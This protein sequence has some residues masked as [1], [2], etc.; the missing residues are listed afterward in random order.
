MEVEELRLAFSEADRW[1]TEAEAFKRDR[2]AF[3]LDGQ[4]GSD[5]AAAQ[6]GLFLHVLPLGRL[7]AQASLAA[8]IT[9]WKPR[10]ED[11]GDEK[12]TIARTNVDGWLRRALCFNDRHRYF[13]LFRSGAAEAYWNL[14][15]FTAGPTPA[16][17]ESRWIE[18]TIVPQIRDVLMWFKSAGVAAPYAIYITLNNAAG[19]VLYDHRLQWGLRTGGF[20]RS[21]ID[22]PPVVLEAMPTNEAEACRPVL[23]ALYQAAGWEVC[24]SF[25]QHGRWLFE[26][27]EDE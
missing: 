18:T 24:P 9:F 16:V 15:N 12:Q 27:H 22:L 25:D 26:G 23:D 3:V 13:Q 6:S 11:R 5:L 14:A 20:D 17:L 1:M 2:V 21:R 10:F 8:G 7:R 19:K 4:L